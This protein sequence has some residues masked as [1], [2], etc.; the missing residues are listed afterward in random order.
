[1]AFRGL[2]NLSG[3]LANVK[4]TPDSAGF[5][6]TVPTKVTLQPG[7][8][9]I[10]SSGYKLDIPKNTYGN[11]T[12][13]SSVSIKQGVILLPTNAIIDADY[14]E[15]IKYCFIN[16]SNE[17]QVLEKGSRVAQM[18]FH[19]YLDP[20]QFNVLNKERDG[21]IGSTNTNKVN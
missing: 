21:G 9:V 15:E 3:D 16:L 10:V 14:K 12:T 6:M 8:K 17:T 11:L 2:V 19:Q 20:D 4:G 13:R 1:M 18:V 5:D 7:E